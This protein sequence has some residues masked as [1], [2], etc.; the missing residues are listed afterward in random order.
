MNRL[1]TATVRL[2]QLP[3]LR[4]PSPSSGCGE[5]HWP[6]NQPPGPVRALPSAPRPSR[7]RR[8]SW[9]VAEGRTPPLTCNEAPLVGADMHLNSPFKAAAL[10]STTCAGRI[11]KGPPSG[12]WVTYRIDLVFKAIQAISIPVATND[13]TTLSGGGANGGNRFS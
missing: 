7:G 1:G 4:T 5:P 2:N 10:G 6:G 11:W 8:R 12:S 13:Y 3:K 9:L